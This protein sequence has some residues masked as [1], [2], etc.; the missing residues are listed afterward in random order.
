M[1]MKKKSFEQRVVK[2]K[3]REQVFKE[4]VIRKE[5][6]LELKRDEEKCFFSV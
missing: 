2:W 1:K 6:Y 5:C 4:E 3:P